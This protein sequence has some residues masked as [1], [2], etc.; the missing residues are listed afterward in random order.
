MPSASLTSF[1]MSAAYKT[2]Q[3]PFQMFETIFDGRY[4][5]LLMGLF[6]VYT[7]LIYNDCFSKSFNIFGTAWNL[8]SDW[9]GIR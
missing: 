5:V 9:E 1:M 3:F 4:I 2:I 7:G 6:A 8:D